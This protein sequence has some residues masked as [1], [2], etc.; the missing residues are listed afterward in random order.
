MRVITHGHTLTAR[1]ST[2]WAISRPLGLCAAVEA[3]AAGGGTTH[4]L[5]LLQLH[6]C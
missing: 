2:E 5:V 6:T 3:R 1:V 4:R